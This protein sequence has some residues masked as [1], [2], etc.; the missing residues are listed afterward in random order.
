MMLRKLIRFIV[1]IVVI[2]L[3]LLMLFMEWIIN[4]PGDRWVFS[5]W[6]DWVT[7]Q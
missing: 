3:M 4:D 6:L 1:A 7:F 2:P 5:G